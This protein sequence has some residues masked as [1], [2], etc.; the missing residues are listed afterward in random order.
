MMN[1][2]LLIPEWT[3]IA[4]LVILTVFELF[5]FKNNELYK[6]IRNLL[7]LSGLIAVSAALISVQTKTGTAFNGTYIADPFAVFF[8]FIFLLAAGVVIQTT[9]EFFYQRTERAHEFFL[10][11]WITLAGFFLLASANDFLIFFLALETVTLG[12]Y[13]LSAY[14]KNDSNSIEA[15]MKYFILGSLASAI[16][17]FGVSLIYVAAGSTL[18]TDV[19]LAFAADPGNPLMLSGALMVL[20]GLFFKAGCFPFQFWIPDVYEGAPTPAVSFL[21]VASKAAAFAAILRLL[22]TVFLPLEEKSAMLFGVLAFTTLLY[23]NLGALKQTQMKR[24]LGYSSIGHAGY[25]LIGVAA[26]RSLGVSAVLYY[27]AAYAVTTLAVFLCVTIAS[28]E[29]GSDRI[30]AY[31]GLG[32]KS[33]FLAGMLFLALLSSAGIPPLAGFSG[34]FLILLASMQAGLTTLTLVGILTVV[35]SLYYYLA[36]V[37]VMYFEKPAAETSIAL[38]PTSRRVLILL[39]LL[40]VGFGIFQAPLIHI[41]E[42]AARFLF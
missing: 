20:A 3:I 19:R 35:I 32:Q 29:L 21:S 26:G 27:L 38:C 16:L 30:D 31:R 42:N 18:F 7:H 34:K 8:K 17:I 41:T 22:H 39:A 33:P 1:L 2:S 5:S 14:L 23:G 36:V 6:K 37:R 10:V 28:R 4:T 25:L 40:I 12:F 15:G 24:L 11:L 13:V 9:R